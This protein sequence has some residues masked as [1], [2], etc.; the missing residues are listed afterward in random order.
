MNNCERLCHG[1]QISGPHCQPFH[2]F[3]AAVWSS[4]SICPHLSFPTCKTRSHHLLTKTRSF[5]CLWS[6]MNLIKSFLLLPM[7]WE[8][9]LPQNMFDSRIQNDRRHGQTF[10]EVP[11]LLCRT[12][13]HCTPQNSCHLPDHLGQASA[14][15]LPPRQ[16]ATQQAGCL[17][18]C[19][20]TQTTYK[21]FAKIP[22][23]HLVWKTA[24]PM[25]AL[26]A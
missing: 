25:V 24:V 19:F 18:H 11:K 2:L 26:S 8:Q 13:I 5:T 6:I 16:F 3:A 9:K 21:L 14:D 12:S 20:G 22:F 4:R 17:L 23:L 7:L 10:P 15:R 1:N